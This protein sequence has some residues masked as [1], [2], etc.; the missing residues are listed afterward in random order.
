MKKVLILNNFIF[1]IYVYYNFLYFLQGITSL[2]K[3][4]YCT[5]TFSFIGEGI[6]T[7]FRLELYLFPNIVIKLNALNSD[8]KQLKLKSSKK[9]P[10]NTFCDWIYDFIQ[11]KNVLNLSKVC[12][13]TIWS[14]YYLIIQVA[15]RAKNV[16]NRQK[17]RWII[18]FIGNFTSASLKI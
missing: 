1:Y 17:K 11:S 16:H 6:L 10:N 5:R 18:K 3:K 2:K 4:F 12:L 15:P 14:G 7:P 13:P 9:N 8:W